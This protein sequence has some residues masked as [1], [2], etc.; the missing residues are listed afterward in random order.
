MKKIIFK[1]ALV[2]IVIIGIIVAIISSLHN[3]DDVIVGKPIATSSFEKRIQ[4]R[5][6]SEITGKPYAE[7]RVGFLSILQEINTEASITLGNDQKK[8]SDEET[9]KSKKII[10]YEY[11]PIFTEFG[12]NYFNRSSWDDATIK[13]L[14]NEALTLQNMKIAEPKTDVSKGL[15]T[16]ISTVNDYY[17]AWGVAKGASSCSSISAISAIVSSAN[18]YKRK[19]LTNNASL[20]AALNSVESNAKGAVVRNIVV[21][22]NGVASRNKSHSNYASWMT[23]YE[24]ACNRI[25]EYKGAYGY[26]SELQHARATL[27]NAD[28]DALDYYSALEQNKSQY[29]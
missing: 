21:Y 7:A 27:D 29:E 20:A 2:L 16:I 28:S 6:E 3:I 23:T 14:Q 10:F 4:N 24:N 18:K 9:L 17:A 26:P 15:A 22:C 1:I 11:A 12:T 8:L 19:P 13:S 5:C 25:N